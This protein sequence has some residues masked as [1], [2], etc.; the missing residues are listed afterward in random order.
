VMKH[1]FHTDLGPLKCTLSLGVASYPD[2]SEAKHEIF[3][4]TDQCL[5]HCKRMGRNRST[6]VDEMRR[7]EVHED[8]A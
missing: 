2:V 7:G 5:Y 8:A 4:K 1:E 6:T 3:E